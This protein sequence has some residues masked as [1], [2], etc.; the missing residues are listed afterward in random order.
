MS[1]RIYIFKDTDEKIEEIAEVTRFTKAEIVMLAINR[2][3]D[4]RKKHV[5]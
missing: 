1:T 2:L 4:R 5:K 3:Y